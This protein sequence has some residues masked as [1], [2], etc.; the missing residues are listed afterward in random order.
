MPERNLQIWILYES[1]AINATTDITPAIPA[2]QY[3]M[4][5]AVM[6]RSAPTIQQITEI[7]RPFIRNTL[8]IGSGGRN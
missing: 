5:S 7:N 1:I 8:T 6:P 3:A 2:S 4:L